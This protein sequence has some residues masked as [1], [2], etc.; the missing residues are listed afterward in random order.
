[1]TFGKVCLSSV[2]FTIDE[3]EPGCF[4]STIRSAPAQHVMAL[5]RCI[6]TPNSSSQRTVCHLGTGYS[7]VGNI[8][9]ALL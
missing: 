4:H 9:F 7:T 6:L 1:M 3:T 5:A 8:Q 2:G